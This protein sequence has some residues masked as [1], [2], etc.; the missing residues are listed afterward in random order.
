MASPMPRLEPVTTPVVTAVR[1]ME[2]LSQG[3]R[4]LFGSRIVVRSRFAAGARSHRSRFTTGSR[5]S[6]S[7]STN[8]PGRADARPRRSRRTS[9]A[10]PASAGSG[11]RSPGTSPG[12]PGGLVALAVQY[13]HL[14]TLISEGYAARS[15]N[16]IHDVLDPDPARTMP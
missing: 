13:G 7:G 9:T 5:R 16:G 11:A 1:V 15:R 14:R 2:R 4:L 6:P 8:I 10:P 12:D 3:S